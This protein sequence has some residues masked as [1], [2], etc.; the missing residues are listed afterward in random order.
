MFILPNI[1]SH[2]LFNTYLSFAGYPLQKWKS[3][4]FVLLL[5]FFLESLKGQSPVGIW[6]TIDDVSG[7]ERGTVEI[8]EKAGIVYAKVIGTFPKPGEPAD[9]QCIA[10]KGE[11]KNQRVIGM[12]IMRGLKKSGDEWS[13]GTILDPESGNEYSCYIKLLSP[14]KLKIRGYIGFSL[15]GRSQYWY[16]IK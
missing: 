7:K 10:C 4:L 1:L 3:A 8:Y 14:D 11:R 15:F 9:P 2:F 12:E 16:R 13:G 5:L 6:K